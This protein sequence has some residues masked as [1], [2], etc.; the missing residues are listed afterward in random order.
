LLDEARIDALQAV[1]RVT[2]RD[3]LATA[4]LADPQFAEECRIARSEI[5]RVLGLDRLV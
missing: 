5:V 1:V 4:D 2:Y 3:R